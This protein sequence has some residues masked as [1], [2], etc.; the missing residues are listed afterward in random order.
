LQA[1]EKMTLQSFGPAHVERDAGYAKSVIWQI[2]PCERAQPLQGE[3]RAKLALWRASGKTGIQKLKT[4]YVNYFYAVN[5]PLHA[6]HGSF[7]FKEN[8]LLV[9]VINVKLR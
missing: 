7:L 9:V 3:S 1:G 8:V 2:I 5:V 4:G 6:V